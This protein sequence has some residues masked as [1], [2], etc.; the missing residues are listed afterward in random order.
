MNIE[1]LGLSVRAYNAL[2]RAGIDTLA[3]IL[4]LT[5]S[6]LLCI[7]G[8]GISIGMEIIRRVCDHGGVMKGGPAE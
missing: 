6:Q 5:P 3:Q 1:E 2:K 4:E 7:R 8:I